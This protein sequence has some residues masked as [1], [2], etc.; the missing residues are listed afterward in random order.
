MRRWAALGLLAVGCAGARWTPPEPRPPPESLGT[1]ELVAFSPDDDLLPAIS[2]D[3]RF[4]AYVSQQ[5][6]NLDVYVRDFR[7]QASFPV[8]TAAADDFDP[9]LF[10]ERLA[11]VSR[12]D[13]AKGDIYVRKNGLTGRERRL[14][15][16]KSADR[17]PRFSPDG[18]TLY[19]VTQPE[20]SLQEHIEA[21]DL[22]GH[23]RRRITPGPGFDPAPSPDGR[24][25][26]YTEPGSATRP[27][28]H[29]VA[30]RLTDGA[31]VALSRS[32]GPEGFAQFPPNDPTHVIYVR[33]PDDDDG[34]GVLEV[35]DQASLWEL[36]VDLDALFETGPSSQPPFPLTDGSD[37]ELFPA[38][39]P[40]FVY[41]TQ[42]TLQQDILRIPHRGVFPRYAE[43]ER[44]FELAQAV[45]DPRT[46][47]FALRAVEATPG[48]PR[49]QVAR[50]RYRIGMLQLDR[51][52]SD[53]ARTEFEQLL[54]QPPD[55]DAERTLQ[56]LAQV[57]L[58]SLGPVD[59]DRLKELE[60]EY[61][62]LD[63]VA[64]RLGIARAQAAYARGRQ[65]EALD[66]LDDVCRRHPRQ[67]RACAQAELLRVEWFE[68]TG[69]PS[70]VGRAYAKVMKA[71]PEQRDLLVRAAERLVDQVVDD[72]VALSDPSA[73]VRALRRVLAEY[74]NVLIA[75]TA[76]TSLARRFEE[77]QEVDAAIW[78]LEAAL[79]LA[80]DD[81]LFRARWLRKLAELRDAAG[82]TE[83]AL[84]AWRELRALA[85]DLPV[86]AAA[87]RTAIVRTN[88]RRAEASEQAGQLEAALDAYSQVVAE[89]DSQ[90]F[91][92]RRQVALTAELGRIGP[93]VEQA[94][95]L[96]STYPN[97]PTAH[98]RLGLARS[99]QRDLKKA[100]KDLNRA[101][102]LN[103]QMASAYL[104]LGWVLEMRELERPGFFARIGRGMAQGFRLAFGVG[105][106]GLGA[107]GYL[108]LAIDAYDRAVRLNRESV[109]PEFEAEALLN[110]GNALYRLADQS[111]D[112]T[113]FELAFQ[114]YVEALEQGLPFRGGPVQEYV[115]WERLGRAAAWSRAWAES[116]TAT[117]K[118]LA[119]AEAAGVP[120]RRAQLLG[121]LALAFDQANLPEAARDS[122]QDFRQA[123]DPES[124]RSRLA[125]ALRDQAR[126]RLEG[127]DGSRDEVLCRTLQKL[128]E[129]E[130]LLEEAG[131]DNGPTP[132][133]WRPVT[134]NT[135]RALF[136]F[137][138]RSERAVQLAFR[139]QAHARLGDR[140]RALELAADRAALNREIERKIPNGGL[141]L[142]RELITLVTLRERIGLDV[143]LALADVEAGRTAQGLNRLDA[144]RRE[145]QGWWKSSARVEDRGA[146]AADLGHLDALAVELR[147]QVQALDDPQKW[148]DRLDLAVGRVRLG[149]GTDSAQPA[150]FQ[151]TT[152]ATLAWT[153]TPTVADVGD[154]Y[155]PIQHARAAEARIRYA[156]AHLL[157]ARPLR[158]PGSPLEALDAYAD[159]WWRSHAYLLEAIRLGVG[160]GPAG[161]R[162]AAAAAFDGASDLK[163]LGKEAEDLER[164]AEAL[165][166]A[167]GAFDAWVMHRLR[168]A[169]G[170]DDL[171]EAADRF[172]PVFWRGAAPRLV[173]A[174]VE[175]ARTSTEANVALHALDRAALLKTFSPG[176]PTRAPPRFPSESDR[177][178]KLRR[179]AV[180]HGGAEPDPE[181]W[182]RV[183]AARR[184]VSGLTD[185]GRVR[186]FA[187][188]L[189]VSRWA[190][191]L[192]PEDRMIWLLPTADPQ[193]VEVWKVETSSTAGLAVTRAEMEA[194]P[195]TGSQARAWGE[196]ALGERPSGRVYWIATLLP[197]ADR[198]APE[199]AVLVTAPSV[200][201]LVTRDRTAGL[202]D[203]VLAT[204]GP[205]VAPHL[206]L[207]G[208]AGPTWAA[209]GATDAER[210]AQA[211]AASPL[212]ELRVQGI[213]MGPARVPERSW[214][215]EQDDAS[216]EP[217]STA[218]VLIAQANRMRTTWDRRGHLPGGLDLTL[219][220]QGVESASLR[221]KDCIGSDEECTYWIG[222]PPL[223]DDALVDLVRADLKDARGAA[224]SAIRSGRYE[225]ASTALRRWLALEK[226]VGESRYVAP[227]YNALVGL[228]AE[229]LEPSQP[230]EAAAVQAEFVAYL[231]SKDADPRDVA[232][233]RIRL[234]LL[235]HKADRPDPA[236]A[237]YAQ[238]LE[239][240]EA[241]G[242]AGTADLAAARFSYAQV[243]V[244]RLQFQ[245]A[246][247]QI[248]AS[249][250]LFEKAGVYEGSSQ[251]PATAVDALL[252]AGTVA[253]NRLSDPERARAAYA[254]AAERLAGTDAIVRVELAR[255]RLARRTGRPAEAERLAARVREQARRRGERLLELEAWIE[256]ANAA[257]ARGDYVAGEARCRTSLELADA[258]EVQMLKGAQPASRRRIRRQLDV[259]RVYA[260]SVCGLV[261]LAQGRNDRA[262]GR[263]Q[264]ALR[265]AEE[266]GQA[267]EIATQYNNLG[268]AYLELGRTEEATD[269]F[270]RALEI[271]EAQ[272]D[273]Y[274]LAYD[275]RNL[276]QALTQLGSPQARPVLERGLELSTQ[277]SDRA[278]TARTLFALGE[279]ERT[280]GD[281]PRKAAELYRRA[282]E[283]AE[284]VQLLEVLWRIEWALAQ[285]AQQM[286][287]AEAARRGLVR[288]AELLEAG[289]GS[290][291]GAGGQLGPSP[292][293]PFHALIRMELQAG[294]ID[295]ALAWL[296]RV[297]ALE[298]A[299]WQADPRVPRRSD[300]GVPFDVA[301]A[302][303]LPADGA[304]VVWRWMEGEL[305]VA[306]LR[307][308]VREVRVVPAPS[309]PRTLAA[310]RNLLVQ[311]AEVG[312]QLQVLA[313][314]LI[315]PVDG[316]LKGARRWAVVADGALQYVTESALPWPERGVEQV[317]DRA[318]VWRAPS[319]SAAVQSF[320]PLR[321]EASRFLGFAAPQLD[322]PLRSLP[323][324]AKEM[325]VIGEA[326]PAARV[327]GG[328]AG[329][330]DR[331]VQAL[332]G[333]DAWLHFAGHADL[334]GETKWDPLDGRLELSDRPVQ[335]T[336]VLTAT[337][338]ASV[339]VLSSCETGIGRSDD[340]TFPAGTEVQSFVV[341]FQTAGVDWVVAN[342]LSIDDAAA[343][344]FSKHLYRALAEEP[345]QDALRTAR[346]AVRKKWAHP[347]W[348]ATPTAFGT[349]DRPAAGETAL[350]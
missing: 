41:F 2:E 56:G 219:W 31:T 220:A 70:L 143:E 164:R 228:L 299:R 4:L 198:A 296:A 279:W 150:P 176:L 144:V 258:V 91:A 128:D 259:R 253:M 210:L 129:A 301:T 156:Q 207:E 167:V 232:K 73:R 30:L 293:A 44:F 107:Q 226:R 206:R 14:T 260:L 87:A 40:A 335:V 110:L 120:R 43:P 285:T 105:D 95:R 184:S 137:D 42:G 37:N 338:A 85:K 278:N 88:L 342:L 182:G 318:A 96:R 102:D 202:G 303:Q 45:D 309:L 61:R 314:H 188:P 161:I 12:R 212:A 229:Q 36:E 125:V 298:Q 256:A 297:R 230:A 10:G 160:A 204:P 24:Y 295:R 157:R 75:R 306:V 180:T 170:I 332:E 247:R 78:E 58:L 276:G 155:D 340:P 27:H 68:P 250:T 195:P 264:A 39:G 185:Y 224:L 215:A 265:K 117:R 77:R 83:S 74:D 26:V 344:S 235:W 82:E 65:G 208:M 200:L 311:R 205:K 118:A 320:Q 199:E 104:A 241:L 243:L 115:F 283:D 197:G 55:G 84:Q 348:W 47:W 148:M 315:Q 249:V 80:G 292:T 63:P 25:L 237:A 331:F 239:G 123:L 71:Y 238:G 162:V 251:P 9:A 263:L 233:A 345:L 76:R 267:Q 29:L 93:Y 324:V 322:H 333:P 6:G 52:R 154:L 66:L 214:W 62:D 158:Q 274:G 23:G 300:P 196:R 3:G 272:R 227:V 349:R 133:L 135:S 138:A 173:D 165:A 291:A 175:G 146:H 106:S 67:R 153:L 124:D 92:L 97:S 203:E 49:V 7:T 273:L 209:P 307:A 159:G 244:D 16:R 141:F 113:N 172:P 217:G 201:A 290:G 21:M 287:Q 330:A 149:D 186:L 69:Q 60:A 255:V 122:L 130:E 236:E 346:L 53:L 86:F 183:E 79:K 13:D 131:V 216:Q 254:R 305:L 32:G 211:A 284:A 127:P 190:S 59:R 134:G 252:E 242:D 329:Q 50:A 218:D 313:E 221:W 189:P 48:A 191:G 327:D 11:Y 132:S 326:H 282:L 145:V 266:L 140:E 139:Q 108:E 151:T 94:A 147:I 334:V 350:P 234:G 171:H 312:S 223:D 126:A 281:D 321:F 8:T 328:G 179:L 22:G 1:P 240:L 270:R 187:D 64:A 152:T 54:A 112:L 289:A 90:V 280:V 317:V 316:A 142:S 319:M 46:Q 109:D 174:L 310:F 181:L 121:N 257:W 347:A 20:G 169:G 98:Y 246:A 57:E 193:R 19:F 51:G 325:E 136:G 17:Q 38:V 100:A 337:A 99:Y 323:F 34:S 35:N 248:E 294:A 111:N 308:D 89:D 336:E 114:R 119:L 268:R 177:I 286:G 194:P 116:I 302:A 168:T 33:F 103:P 28:P 213:L 72:L 15:D 288:S 225:V 163:W 262:L 18:R 271:D 5:N 245:Q 277:V 231:E 275:H 269:A 304:V 341:A 339:V 166:S 343:A 192:T 81:T 101:I 261:A 222:A 178:E